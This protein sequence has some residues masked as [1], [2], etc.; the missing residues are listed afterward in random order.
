MGWDGDEDIV[1]WIDQREDE[2]DLEPFDSDSDRSYDS[3]SDEHF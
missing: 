2:S 3:Y 1:E